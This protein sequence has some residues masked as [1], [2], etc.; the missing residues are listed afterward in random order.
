MNKQ[1]YTLGILLALPFLVACQK[2]REESFKKLLST[3][4]KTEKSAVEIAKELPNFE[5]ELN[6]GLELANTAKYEE[7]IVYFKKSLQRSP[8]SPIAL[9]NICAQYN[10]LKRWVKAAEHC[11]LAL[12]KAPEFQLA[13]NNLAFAE[14]QL[15]QQKN[16]IKKLED[17]TKKASADKK[18]HLTVDLGFEYYKMGDY[19][20]AIKVWS[21]VKKSNDSL[22]TTTLNNLGSA[23]IM[24]NNFQEARQILNQASQREPANELVKNNIT[25]LNDVESKQ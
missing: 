7:A 10:N 22:T 23:H 19:T 13:K 6:A 25:W 18:R 12:N 5:N 4:T 11:K 3:S 9:N 24:L 17:E 21:S 2:N 16:V 14:S 15:V 20:K 8:E 1:F